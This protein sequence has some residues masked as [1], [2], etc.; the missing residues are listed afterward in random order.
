MTRGTQQAVS[1]IAVPPLKAAPSKPQRPP[2]GASGIS[3]PPQPVTVTETCSCGG[4]VEI[5]DTVD[6]THFLADWRQSH[7]HEVAVKP[8]EATAT[9]PGSVTTTA[10]T[11]H[12]DGR[13]P[14]F[15]FA[16]RWRL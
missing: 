9:D 6:P 10:H 2:S 15:G 14:T 4:K 5:R 7:R 12:E 8:G 3:E 13:P 1:G 11:A 16:P